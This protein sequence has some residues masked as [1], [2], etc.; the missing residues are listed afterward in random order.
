V[1]SLDFIEGLPQSNRHNTILVVID[2]FSKY[3]HFIPLAHP[4][5][6][7]QVAQAYFTPVYLLHGLPQTLISY[8]DRAF[9]SNLWQ[10][11]FRLSDTQLIMSSSYHTKMDGQT[12]HLNQC[13]ETYLGSTIHNSL[14]KWFSWLPLAEYRYNTTYHSVKVH[15]GPRVGFE[16][17]MTNN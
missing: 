13:L 15:L 1:V 8:R 5:T 2:K 9:M 12:K 6:V 4:F 14:S 3:A 17:L 11:L 16:G 10:E 7:L